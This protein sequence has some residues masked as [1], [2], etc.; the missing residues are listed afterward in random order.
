MLILLHSNAVFII[1][2]LKLEINISIIASTF[3][4]ELENLEFEEC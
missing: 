2:C 3:G 4:I 1:L